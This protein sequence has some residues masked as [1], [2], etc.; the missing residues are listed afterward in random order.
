[1]RVSVVLLLFGL[2]QFQLIKGDEQLAVEEVEAGSGRL[3]TKSYGEGSGVLA[4]QATVQSD[5]SAELRQLRDMVVEQKVKLQQIEE[6]KK[7]NAALEQRL[8][9]T[10]LEIKSL[11]E[12]KTNTP[13]VAFSF[14]TGISGSH[15]PLSTDSIL[16]LNREITNIGNAFSPI[17]GVFTAP[18]RGVYYFRYT[19]SGH[20]SA[21]WTTVRLMKNQRSIVVATKP[22]KGTHDYA[23]SGATLL[24]EK[25]DLVYLR[26]PANSQFWDDQNNHFS[27]SGFL[28]FTM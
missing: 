4:D 3:Q 17:T 5:V 12:E 8:A 1:M 27:F 9:F 6:L 13:K 19:M 23:A 20:S 2:T 25:G 26:L 21:H 11:R 7:E 15:G 10:E 22:P 28:L 24:L 14:G 18:V 16:V